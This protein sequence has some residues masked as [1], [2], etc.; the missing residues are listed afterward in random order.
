MNAQSYALRL[1]KS[2]IRS[3]WELDQAL[4]RRGVEEA[5]RTKVIDLLKEIKLVDDEQFA[6]AWLHTRDRLSPRGE[7]VLKM[8]LAQKGISKEIIAQ[9]LAERKVEISE[10]GDG[11]TL[12]EKEITQGKKIIAGK[13]RAL[14]HLDSETRNRRLTALLLRRGFSYDTAR[15]I[16]DV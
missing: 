3:A 1:L 7:Y 6:R 15:R 4:M 11:E 16:L 5:E 13:Q 12:Q 9:A 2:R 14:A 8:E 10:E